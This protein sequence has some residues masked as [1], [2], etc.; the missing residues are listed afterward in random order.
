MHNFHHLLKN[1]GIPAVAQQVKDL[2][3]FLRW[4]RLFLRWLRLLLR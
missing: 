2:V 1:L 4:L 3:L